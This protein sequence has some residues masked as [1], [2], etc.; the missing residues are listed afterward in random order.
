MDPDKIKS[1]QEW[2][3]CRSVHDIQ[4][5]L[6]LTNFYRRFIKDYS[7]IC[8]P[9]TALLKKDVKFIWSK[10]ADDAFNN[11]KHAITSD[12]I[13][14]HYDPSLPCIVE[15]D[16]SDFALGAVCSQQFPGD[17]VPHPIAFYS[18]KLLPAEQN[19]QVYDKELLAIVAA[20]KHWRPYL[21]FSQEPTI[22]LT[23]HKNLEYFTTTRSLSRRQ[24]RW[25]EILAD[26][27]FVIQY[28]A[29]KH[30]GAADA[31][32][33]RDI[34]LL[35]GGKP[36]NKTSMTL[37]DPSKFVAPPSAVVNSLTTAPVEP[38]NNEIL[39]I[40]KKDIVSDPHFGPIVS[41]FKSTPSDPSSIPSNYSFNDDLLFYN[42][43]ICTPSNNQVKKLILE[44]CHDAPAAGH[45][46]ISKTHDLVTRNYY[47]PQLRKY[48]KDYVSG[49]EPVS[50]TRVSITSHMVC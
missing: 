10:E 48:V 26:Y 46:G 27:N 12:P 42:G 30:N 31:L 34:C 43:L 22:I 32:S 11:L 50:E 41:L 7:K 40:I 20:F 15:T 3:P 9:L 47:W 25:S 23:D 14:R 6:G 21:E 8:N 37:L 16:A 49:C 45:F 18:R 24:V 5:F 44:E 33:R 19:Y 38:E 39:D 17:S 13:L 36:S 29:G 2:K 35:E 1:I 4:V 28:R